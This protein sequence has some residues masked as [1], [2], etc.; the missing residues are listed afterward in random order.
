MSFDNEKIQSI[1]KLAMLSVDK[2]DLDETIENMDSIMSL[3]DQMQSV[4]TDNIEPLSHPQDPV[5]RLRDDV[6][7]ES[8]QRDAFQALTPH[9]QQGLFT[10]PKVIE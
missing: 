5:L 2:A 3:I 1:A 7:T 4:N 8:S 6:V 9:T 10:V